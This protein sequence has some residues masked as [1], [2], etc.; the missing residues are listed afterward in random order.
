M[1]APGKHHGA[2]GRCCGLKSCRVYFLK[3][4][5]LYF[6]I[7]AVLSCGNSRFTSIFLQARGL[8]DSAVGLALG[9]SSM[10]FVAT[11]FFTAAADKSPDAP[12]RVLQFCLV[13][14]TA[15]F[16][17][18]AV[19]DAGLIRDS[20]SLT[21]FFV[22]SRLLISAVLVPTLPVLDTLCLTSFQNAE[23]Q[24]KYGHERLWGAISW[25][26]VHILIGLLIERFSSSVLY[27]GMPVSTIAALG[28][29][30]WREKQ[31]RGVVVATR[32]A[33][34]CNK[35][36]DGDEQQKLRSTQNKQH[37]CTVLQSQIKF[38]R[39]QRPVF[40]VFLLDVFVLNAGVAIVEGLIF[41]FFSETLHASASLMGLTVVVTVVF[42]IPLFYFSES[43]LNRFTH[44]QLLMLAHVAYVVRVL[45]YSLVTAP[46][47]VLLV[48]PL[49]GVTYAF[50]QLSTVFLLARMAP[51]GLE[52][53]VQGLRSVVAR[54]GGLTGSICG[55]IVLER[56]G[57]VVLYRSAAALVTVVGL[58]YFCS[59]CGCWSSLSASGGGGGHGNLSYELAA[60]E[61][62]EQEL[63]K[64]NAYEG[65]KQDCDEIVLPS[66]TVC[67][68]ASNN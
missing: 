9:L 59:T 5:A 57:A 20:L 17:V 61:E 22:L 16:L 12:S 55:G 1:Q 54:L 66:E 10:S 43:V 11:P 26:V 67:T 45:G 27:A 64:E 2:S 37:L 60:L 47:M 14:A 44:L 62:Q 49:H 41:L 25:G 21:W 65:H 15:L 36:E 58:I 4:R 40:W 6:V 30:A 68:S 3:P 48:E 46:W 24:K 63:G 34:A 32:R 53:S 28:L 38:I 31:R 51:A 13:L 52:N 33:T 8:S 23:E 19:V 50:Y 56:F 29:I 42:E 7:F 39:L 18:Q 35:D